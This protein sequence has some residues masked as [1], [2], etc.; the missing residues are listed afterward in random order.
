MKLIVCLDENNGMTFNNRRQS[1][2]R[3]VGERIKEIVCPDKKIYISLKSEKL[4]E[5]YGLNY[6]ADEHYL[7]KAGKDDYCFCE[8]E[9]PKEADID[10]IIVFRW[11]RKY[12]QDTSFPYDLNKWKAGIFEVFAGNSHDEIYI[13]PYNK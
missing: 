7:E 5:E 9:L 4:F 11:A 3:V 12:P 1:K 6:I 2:D 13:E 8:F 10:E